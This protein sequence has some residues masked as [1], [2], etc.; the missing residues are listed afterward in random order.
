MLRMCSCT[1]GAK[2]FAILF[3]NNLILGT[4]QQSLVK[5]AWAFSQAVAAPTVSHPGA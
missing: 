3:E 2:F 1:E 5:R 4:S